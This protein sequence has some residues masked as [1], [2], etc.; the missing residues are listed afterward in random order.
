MGQVGIIDIEK[1]KI[2]ILY[3]MGCNKK[4]QCT[5]VGENADRD[6]FVLLFSICMLFFMGRTR[7]LMYLY[8]GGTIMFD[9]FASFLGGWIYI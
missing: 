7:L 5:K 4:G 6:Y 8:I 9:C 1:G 3:S 2:R